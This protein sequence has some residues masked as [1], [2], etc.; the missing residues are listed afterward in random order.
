M[1]LR[2]EMSPDFIEVDRVVPAVAQGLSSALSPD[3]LMA[4]EIALAEA[5]TNAVKHAQASGTPEVIHV[6]AT[7]LPESVRIEIID[8]GDQSP[9][10]L[11]DDVPQVGDIDPLSDGGRGIPLISHLADEVRFEPAHGRNLL[12]LV[13]RREES[14]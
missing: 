11:Y 13:F 8:A 10:D 6:T 7:T 12:R 1:V 2:L 5:L 14:A 3:K 4:V 9:A